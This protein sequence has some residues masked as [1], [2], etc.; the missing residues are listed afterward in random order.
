MRKIIRTCVVVDASVSKMTLK[1]IATLKSSGAPAKAAI[2]ECVVAAILIGAC[3]TAFS[4]IATKTLVYTPIV[5]RNPVTLIYDRVHPKKVSCND[6]YK[7]ITANEELSL[8][9]KM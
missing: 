3:V 2:T 6:Q 9:E 5:F 4:V 7:S 1:V 8:G